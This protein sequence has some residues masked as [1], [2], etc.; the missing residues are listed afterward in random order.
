MKKVRLHHNK[1]EALH[2][3]LR[4]YL[5]LTPSDPPTP[6]QSSHARMLLPPARSSN[7]IFPDKSQKENNIHQTTLPIQTYMEA[8]ACL[9]CAYI[10]IY[11][12]TLYSKQSKATKNGKSFSCLLFLSN[13]PHLLNLPLIILYLLNIITSIYIFPMCF[14]Q[15]CRTKHVYKYICPHSLNLQAKLNFIYES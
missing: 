3:S 12:S 9:P 4:I 8:P 6:A 11:I 14:S 13:L 1:I 10:Y 15:P 7:L 5:T 2:Q